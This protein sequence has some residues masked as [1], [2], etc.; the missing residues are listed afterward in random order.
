MKSKSGILFFI[1]LL[2]LMTSCTTA[3][4]VYE[5]AEDDSK[6]T[7]D[8]LNVSL[9]NSAISMYAGITGLKPED[10]EI[11]GSSV[12]VKE[13][14]LKEVPSDPWGEGRVYRIIDG[15]AKILGSP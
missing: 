10:G 3:Q 5:K 1:L 12:L 8:A 11:T 14:Y 13:G 15:K 7:V 6:I 9:I 4:P 2:M